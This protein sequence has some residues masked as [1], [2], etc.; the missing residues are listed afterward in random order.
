MSE[1][2]ALVVIDMQND[3]VLPR[4]KLCVKG[5][6]ETVPRIRKL[7]D[8][9]R[10]QRLDI[11]HLVREHRDCGSDVEL[12]RLERFERKGKF[13]VSGTE[14]CEIVEGLIPLA[15]EYRIVKRRFSG[16][17]HTE[18][19]LILR[20]KGITHLVV[21]G[22]Q[23]PNCVRATIFDAVC[24]DYH[25]LNI[26][27]CTSAQDEETALANIRDIRNIGVNCLTLEEFIAAFRDFG[28][29]V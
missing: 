13:V 5:A 18:F 22:T 19:D 10:T 2:Y 11:F 24:Y 6:K 20:R 17:F 16:F 8:W 23:Y 12:S 9:F 28:I 7:L 1:K 29:R 26:T 27:D 14:G 3:F 15:D 25:V 21:C 4:G